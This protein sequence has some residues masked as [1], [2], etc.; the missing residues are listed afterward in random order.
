MPFGRLPRAKWQEL[1]WTLRR[2]GTSC[3]Y[4]ALGLVTR[5][6]RMGWRLVY[7]YKSL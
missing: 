6:S 4:F 3:L 1:A 5:L 2:H 7:E